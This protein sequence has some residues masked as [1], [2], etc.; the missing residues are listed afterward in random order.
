VDPYQLFRT[1]ITDELLLLLCCLCFVG[2]S[3]A[4]V[5][6][7]VIWYLTKHNKSESSGHEK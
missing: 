3:F 5:V 1:D 7:L 4:G 6:G 2:V